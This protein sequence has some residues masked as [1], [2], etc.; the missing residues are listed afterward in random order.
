[1]GLLFLKNLIGNKRCPF[2]NSTTTRRPTTSPQCADLFFCKVCDTNFIE[3]YEDDSQISEPS[4]EPLYPPSIHAAAGPQ[5]S[6]HFHPLLCQPCN[7]H[8]SIII[9][10]LAAYEEDSRSRVG[11][12]EEEFKKYRTELDRRYPLCPA[13][14]VAVGERIKQLDFRLRTNLIQKSPVALAPRRTIRRPDYH[15]LF[16]LLL[17]GLIFSL[18][19]YQRLPFPD[20]YINSA[21]TVILALSLLTSRLVNSIFSL[22]IIPLIWFP[23]EYDQY[24]DY[25]TGSLAIIFFTKLAISRRPK[26]RLRV[27]KPLDERKSNVLLSSLSLQE[28][29]IP[30]KS[31]NNNDRNPFYSKSL[32]TPNVKSF[33]NSP[34]Y[35]S[36]FNSSGI[37]PTTLGFQGQ[38][39]GLES[40]FFANVSLRE[41]TRIP[42]LQ[43]TGVDFYS[44]AFVLLLKAVFLFGR[45]L[46]AWESISLQAVMFA[47]NF[48]LANQTAPIRKQTWLLYLIRIICVARLIWLG[49]ECSS[50]ARK[51]LLVLIEEKIKIPFVITILTEALEKFVQFKNHSSFVTDSLIILIN[52]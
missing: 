10:L 43:I 28:E 6:T 47:A 17:V 37:K 30:Q 26:R 13:C 32:F 16:N 50:L 21:F 15:S 39:T 41:T 24:K 33:P 45:F 29:N 11:N 9:Q 46:L 48:A 25:Y 40:D 14:K 36:K 51:D 12:F 19:K 42:N 23:T 5:R 49:F 38:S 1:M 8:Q 34:S 3:E 31:N 18:S 2:C 22:L 44:L 20:I 35:S 27:E 7:N 52:N 4:L